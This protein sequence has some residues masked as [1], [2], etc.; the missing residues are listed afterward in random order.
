[1]IENSCCR[2]IST[3]PTLLDLTCYATPHPLLPP[4]YKPASSKSLWL[5]ASLSRRSYRFKYWILVFYFS[6]YRS[7]VNLEGSLMG[8][9]ISELFQNCHF[10]TKIFLKSSSGISASIN[11]LRSLKEISSGIASKASSIQRRFSARFR[12]WSV[13]NTIEPHEVILWRGPF[14]L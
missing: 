7:I 1:M 3:K 12:V 10:L 8:S 6:K 9:A 11:L 4:S 13:S 5:V 14:L 2:A